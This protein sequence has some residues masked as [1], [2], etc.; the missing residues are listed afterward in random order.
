[1]KKNGK[2]FE[3][4]EHVTMSEDDKCQLRQW[5]CGEE[6]R[7]HDL[8][9]ANGIPSSQMRSMLLKKSKEEHLRCC[10]SRPKDLPTLWQFHVMGKRALKMGA[11]IE[12]PSVCP[13]KGGAKY[14]KLGHKVLLVKFGKVKG[15]KIRRSGWLCT[16]CGASSIGAHA[17]S[18]CKLAEV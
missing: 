16:L 2:H 18:V 9:C 14:F 5:I 17:A 10:G 4:L 13:L 7:G 6:D 12:M 15:N 11:E 1:M 3:L 8:V